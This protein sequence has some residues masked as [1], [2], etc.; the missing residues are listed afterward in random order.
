[1]YIVD[2]QES[3]VQFRIQLERFQV[4]SVVKQTIVMVELIE[5]FHQDFFL[6]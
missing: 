6:S 4:V 2:V 3:V 5:H 1:M